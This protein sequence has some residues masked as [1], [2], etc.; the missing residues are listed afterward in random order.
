MNNQKVIFVDIDGT[1]LNSD[2]EIPK[3]TIEAIQEAKHKGHHVIIATGRAPFMFADLREELELDSYVSYNG[4]Y[5]VLNGEVIFTNPLKIDSLIE[6]T[7]DAL[8]HNH[9]VVFMDHEDMKANIPEHPF[10]EESIRT[11]KI[12]YFPSHDPYYYKDRDLYQTL[13]FCEEGEEA[14]YEE[15]YTDFDFIRWHP[16]SVDVLPKGGSKSVGI[17]KMLTH[18]DVS[19]E[20]IYAFGDGLN[21]IEMLTDVEHGV[22]MGNALTEVKAAARH[23]TRSVDDDGIYHGMKK[24][25]II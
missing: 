10:I 8:H 24:L 15:K 25:G 7:D 2:K 9:P 12:D 16:L 19:S 14:R 18:L 5:V 3:S 22:A 21:D 13:L 1:I 17:Q 11:L 6:L 4:Q 23:V 20:N